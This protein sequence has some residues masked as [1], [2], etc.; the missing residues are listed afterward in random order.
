MPNSVIVTF[1]GRTVDVINPRPEDVC[2]YDVA[3][4][5]S[6][7]C[8]YTGACKWFYS[9]SQHSVLVSRLCDP[10]YA[11][12]G[13]LHDATEAYLNDMSSPLKHSNNMTPYRVLEEM[14]WKVIRQ[15]LN[16]KE[17]DASIKKADEAIYHAE[18]RVLVPASPARNDWHP[19]TPA[20]DIEILPCWSPANAETRFL[21]RYYELTGCFASIE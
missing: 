11:L 10:E 18:R 20:A 17:L 2:I 19:D 15:A 16:L 12:E 6:N 9:V 13:L 5:L 21:A 7:I 1:T 3:H 8:R 14:H 4:H